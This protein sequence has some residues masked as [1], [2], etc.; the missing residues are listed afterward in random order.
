MMGQMFA[1]NVRCKHK[2]PTSM[3]LA[4]VPHRAVRYKPGIPCFSD[5][6]LIFQISTCV[7]VN[8]LTVLRHALYN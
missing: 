6:S 8:A 7:I 1:C 3:G 2:K 4:A 5:L